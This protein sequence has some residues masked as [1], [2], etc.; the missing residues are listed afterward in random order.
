MKRLIF[1][2]FLSGCYSFKDDCYHGMTT[3]C[4]GEAYPAIAHYQKPNSLG[5]TDTRQRWIDIENCNGYRVETNYKLAKV[6]ERDGYRPTKNYIGVEVKGA[7]DRNGKLI[8]SV[9]HA[10]QNC[11][12]SKGYVFI[13][14]CGRKGSTTDKSICNE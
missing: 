10:F 9:I 14:D 5:K 12:K 3:I 8:P 4:N 1:L 2:L 13:E 6:G 7:I 11:M